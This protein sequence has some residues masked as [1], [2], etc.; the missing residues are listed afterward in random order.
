MIDPRAPVQ[1]T[2]QRDALGNARVLKEED[3][4]NRDGRQRVWTPIVGTSD[5]AMN[6]GLGIDGSSVADGFC[7]IVQDPCGRCVR[8]RIDEGRCRYFAVLS[9]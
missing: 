9:V 3:A 8:C 6:S 2:R 4:D 1:A 7:A 5:V